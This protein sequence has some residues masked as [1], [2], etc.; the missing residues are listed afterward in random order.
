MVL[1]VMRE[2]EPA[3]LLNLS[4]SQEHSFRVRRDLGEE[5][6]HQSLKPVTELIS[7]LLNLCRHPV[8]VGILHL[9]AVCR[10]YEDWN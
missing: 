3:F 5:R 10:D 4:P 9:A 8:R 6:I 1:T 7:S 2:L